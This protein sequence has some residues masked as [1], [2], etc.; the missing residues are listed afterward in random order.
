MK[1]SRTHQQSSFAEKRDRRSKLLRRL[2]VNP[3][4]LAT[5]A[6]IYPLLKQCG[7]VP[8]RVIEV[9]RGDDQV[10]AS[11]SVVASWDALSAPERS[12]LGVEVLE[13]LAI[14]SGLPPRR[15]W[16]AYG[17][18]A[19]LQSREATRAII[20]DALPGIMR[21]TAKDAK[22]AKGFASRE[23]IYKA[24][25]VLPIPQGSTT[26]IN[27][28]GAG[29]ENLDEED[30]TGGM[31]KSADDFLLRCSRAMSGRV[32]PAPKTVPEIIETDVDEDDDEGGG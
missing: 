29:D 19:M 3:E 32:L 20:A 7:I 25:R 27:L 13:V 12:I 28:P 6:K 1:I 26:V 11:Q 17:T 8:A 23:H 5:Q 21:V 18:A 10:E 2:G 22:R 4:E 30:D 14:S 16:E 15:L 31:L 9:L 24:A